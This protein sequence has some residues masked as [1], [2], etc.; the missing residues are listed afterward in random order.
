KVASN[1]SETFS[2]HYYPSTLNE[3]GEIA[4]F[5][6]VPSGGGIFV[7]REKGIEQIALQGQ[8]APIKDAKFIGFGQRAPVLN[9]RGDVL[10]VGFVDGPNN[11]RCLFLKREH[12]PVELAAKDGQTIPGT[13][14]NFTDFKEP[15]LN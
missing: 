4:W 8:P 6:R 15:Q 1:S 7:L 13:T 11:G 2:E 9:N 14:S 3:R 12:G 10:F 5:S